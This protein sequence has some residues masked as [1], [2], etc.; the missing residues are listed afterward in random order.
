VFVTKTLLWWPSIATKFL[1]ISLS[2][3]SGKHECSPE[4]C[5][6]VSEI[7]EINKN[8]V[9]IDGHHNNKV[10]VTPAW[11]RKTAYHLSVRCKGQNYTNNITLLITTDD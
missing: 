1:F 4:T 10:W 2:L 7:K 5:S 8:F 11:V 3:S 9:A 6:D